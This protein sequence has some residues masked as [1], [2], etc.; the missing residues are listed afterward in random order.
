MNIKDRSATCWEF[1][2]DAQHMRL[3]K[4]KV[5]FL[6]LAKPSQTAEWGT[7]QE[8]QHE[9][10]DNQRGKRLLNSPRAAPS[11][12]P[13]EPNLGQANP[14]LKRV[15]VI[16][17]PQPRGEQHLMGEISHN[18][19]HKATSAALGFPTLSQANE[20]ITIKKALNPQI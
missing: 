12:S 3:S 15:A 2:D 6:L 18:F 14:H 1:A 5:C 10:A 13:S 20:I 7:L 9:S 8:I 16:K 19:L 4:N 11:S 17:K